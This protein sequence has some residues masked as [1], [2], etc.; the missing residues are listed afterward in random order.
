MS[1]G[2]CLVAHGS[3]E[4]QSNE[5][6][7]KLCAAVAARHPEW[8]VQG[9]F[10]E[11]ARPEFPDVLG[12]MAAAGVSPIA[13]I[14]YFL[15][16]GGHADDDIPGVIATAQLRNPGTRFVYGRALS[17]H[18][19]VTEILVDEVPV[20]A[21]NAPK[22]AV[23]LVA[24][25]SVAASNRASLERLADEVRKRTG[26]STRFGYLDLGEPLAAAGLS[27]V[28][29]NRAPY[30]TVLPCLLFPGVFMR[31]LTRLVEGFRTSYEGVP[32]KL[33]RPF[34]DDPRVLGVIEAE[35][36]GLLG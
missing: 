1:A 32:I 36:R 9:S 23:V 31:S 3:P 12:E 13:V 29:R 22:S 20:D 7:L 18:K 11:R 24:A 27:E 35:I 19:D 2:V 16:P 8:K 15:F 6:F 5:E 4:L 21:L 34:G 33:G 26:L 30:V 14:P 17:E 28:L 25:G 10:L